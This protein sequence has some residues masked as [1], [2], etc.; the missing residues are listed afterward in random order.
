MGRS[1]WVAPTQAKVRSLDAGLN[2]ALGG[3]DWREASFRQREGD[4]MYLNGCHFMTDSVD[5][6]EIYLQ[7]SIAKQANNSLM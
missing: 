5:I 2:R 6:L 4:S 3:R 1:F 7:Y